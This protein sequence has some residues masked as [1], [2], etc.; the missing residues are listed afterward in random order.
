MVKFQIGLAE[1]L[2]ALS[3]PSVDTSHF[4]IAVLMAVVYPDQTGHSWEGWQKRSSLS[5]LYA[6]CLI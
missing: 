1:I 3:G 5:I 4:V 2:E 6:W